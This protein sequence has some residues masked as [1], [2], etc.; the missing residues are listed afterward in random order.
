LFADGPVHILPYDPQCNELF[1]IYMCILPI[2]IQWHH[3]NK[4]LKD[5]SKTPYQRPRHAQDKPDS[6]RLGT[7]VLM[8]NNLSSDY[9][10]GTVWE[11]YRLWICWMFFTK[12]I[13]KNNLYK[14]LLSKN[15]MNSAHHE[16]NF[17]QKLNMEILI[18]RTNRW[19]ENDPSTPLQLS[20][21]KNKKNILIGWKRSRS[22]IIENNNSLFFPLLL[23]ESENHVISILQ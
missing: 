3:H 6:V 17:K 12:C 20:L 8:A 18:C 11:P 13:Y 21:F 1:A 23:F 14:I 5:N 10:W 16:L 22:V 7:C 2:F 9:H 19:L 15:P 4:T